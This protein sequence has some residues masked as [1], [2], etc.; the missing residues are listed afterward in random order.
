MFVDGHAHLL[1]QLLFQIVDLNKKKK[2]GGEGGTKS[3]ALEISSELDR[4]KERQRKK[5][6]ERE[7]YFACVGALAHKRRKGILIIKTLSV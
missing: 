5:R 2:G 4:K 1:L 6:D 7:I 3:F